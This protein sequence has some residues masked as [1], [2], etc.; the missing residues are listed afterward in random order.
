M[1][2][3]PFGDQNPKSPCMENNICTK[4][5]LNFFLKQFSII[6]VILIRKDVIMVKKLSTRIFF[7]IEI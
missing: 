5:F 4:K 1:I 6:L 3:G 7:T 2:H